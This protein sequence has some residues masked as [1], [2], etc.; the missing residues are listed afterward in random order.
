MTARD[1]AA[2]KDLLDPEIAPVVEAIPDIVLTPDALPAIRSGIAA[3]R[4]KLSDTVVRT[5]SCAP[6]SPS[7]PLRVHR[8][9]D[10]NGALPCVYS[11]HGGGYV[12]GSY[13]MDDVL[14]DQWCPKLGI[15]GV[16][17]EYR[18]APETPYPG[19]LEDCYAGLLWAYEHA[20]DFGIDAARIGVR[21]L[22]A[23]GGLAAGLAL[24]ARERGEV[25][26]AF[27]L[28]DS[29]MLDDRQITPSSQLDGL[30]MWTREANQFGWRAYLGERYGRDDVPPYA[31]AARATDLVG[32][33][34]SF[35]SVGAL[36]GFRDEAIEYA[37]RLNQAGVATELHVY[38][39]APHGYTEI[40]PDA[41][42]CR[43]SKRDMEEWLLRQVDGG[44]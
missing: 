36:D 19:P 13:D 41:D 42:V 11:V 38:P 4:P 37:R 2:P 10:A 43:R 7:V 23:G 5:D 34:P 25:P 22:S 8:P 18:L 44:G 9:V 40:A 31:A 12:L 17:V 21:G 26:L 3:L 14:F 24:L 39:G 30:A 33:P 29:P 15:V 16:A 35:V 28:L 32:L 20:D 27:Q 1:V 6:G